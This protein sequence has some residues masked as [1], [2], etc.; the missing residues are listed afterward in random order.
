[1]SAMVSE[2]RT[3]KVAIQKISWP[4]ESVPSQYSAEGRMSRGTSPQSVGSYGAKKERLAKM[5][6][7]TKIQN[8][9]KNLKSLSKS[10]N[11]FTLSALLVDK[12]QPVVS[13][14]S[15]PSRGPL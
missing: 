7:I 13:I 11:S 15:P 2:L 9:Q 14:T 4:L 10:L 1:M 12:M 8:P 6:I 3:A 5:T